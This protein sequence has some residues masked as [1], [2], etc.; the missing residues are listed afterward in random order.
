MG[1]IVPRSRAGA[2]VQ[3]LHGR[4]GLPVAARARCGQ[5]SRSKPAVGRH[6]NTRIRDLVAGVSRPGSRPADRNR[7]WPE[8]QL[9]RR[10]YAGAAGARRAWGGDRRFLSAVAA[11]D[12]L[13]H[14]R[15]AEPCRSDR[16]PAKPGF[17]LLAG[18]ARRV[19]RLGTGFLGQV[20]P[21]DPIGRRRLPRLDRFL[22]RYLG[23]VARR[24]GHDLY[25]HPHPAD[26]NRDRRGQHRQAE[27]G[28]CHRRSAVSRRRR[29]QT[30]RLSG[31]KCAS[32]RPKPRCRN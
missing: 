1:P 29:D 28:A 2:R 26:A 11:G 24:R 8:P 5:I 17:R 25:R 12:E 14:L 21:R 22:R 23:D 3:R 4:S 6:Q 32:A 30:R 9:G 15:P 10:R 19:G 13:D 20:P 18:L 7:L 31:G 16:D 27:E